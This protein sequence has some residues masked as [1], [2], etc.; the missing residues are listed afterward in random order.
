MRPA[1][2]GREIAL[3][4]A[5]WLWIKLLRARTIRWSSVWSTMSPTIANFTSTM[6]SKPG[7]RGRGWGWVSCGGNPLLYCPSTTDDSSSLAGTDVLRKK[8]SAVGTDVTTLL[9]RSTSGRP[10]SSSRALS[11]LIAGPT[12]RYRASCCRRLRRASS[13]SVV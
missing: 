5:A 2:E 9:T 7:G 6:A 12:V 13:H 10:A 8:D 11:R 4:V 1:G 3:F